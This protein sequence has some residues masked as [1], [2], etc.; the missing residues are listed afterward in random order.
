[1]GMWQPEI[2]WSNVTLL[3]SSVDWAWLMKSTPKGLSPLLAPCPS[4]GLPQN[5]YCWDQLASEETCMVCSCPW[6]FFPSWP[7]CPLVPDHGSICCQLCLLRSQTDSQAEMRIMWQSLYL[8][9]DCNLFQCL[10][11]YSLSIRLATWIRKA[12]RKMK[13]LFTLVSSGILLIWRT[14]VHLIKS[15]VKPGIIKIKRNIH[16]CLK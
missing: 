1:M 5:G 16:T 15:S 11:N 2:F 9:S 6:D 13:R 8:A 12:K 10:L 3:L 14:W 4:S 7:E